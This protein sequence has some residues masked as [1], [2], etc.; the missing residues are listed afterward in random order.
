MAEVLTIVLVV[1][2][3]FGFLLNIGSVSGKIAGL[4]R[5][6]RAKRTLPQ[7]APGRWRSEGE[8][9][10]LVITEDL[11][12]TWT[13]TFQGRWSG[14]GR[15][16]GEIRDGYLIL[17]GSREGTT[18]LGQPVPRGPI[19]IRLKRETETLAGQIQTARVYDVL[20]VRE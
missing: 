3:L 17:D 13:S 15:G 8:T 11:S 18:T 5:R 4:V 12:W 16:R 6:S 2:A 1:A 20:F 19:T 7:F 14:H 9:N 10:T